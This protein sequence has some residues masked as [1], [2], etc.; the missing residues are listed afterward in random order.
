MYRILHTGMTTNYG[1]VESVVMNWYR[2]I[3]REK[4]QFD[5]LVSHKSPLIAYEYEI[6]KLGGHVYRSYYGRKE[7]PFTARKYIEEIFSNDSNI[8]GVHMNLNTL[9]YI[10]PLLVAEKKGLPVRIAHSHNT[11]N[12]NRKQHL[13]TRIM[14]S[15]NKR[16]LQSPKYT[17]MGCSVYAYEYMFGNK[18]TTVIHN[19]I[20]TEKFRFNNRRRKLLRERYGISEK[21]KVIGFIGRLQYQKNPEFL[22]RVFCEYQKKI[23]PNS[24]LMIIGTGP[25]EIKCKEMVKNLFLEDRVIFVGMINETSDYYSLFDVFL[26]PSLF[27]GLPVVLI[28]AQ[29]SSLPCL[30]SNNIRED[31]MITSLI[32]RNE[33]DDSTRNWALHLDQMVKKF[34]TLDRNKDTFVKTVSSAGYD[35]AQEVKI[36]EKM[37][38]SMIEGR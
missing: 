34:S 18:E 9:E 22:L 36:L 7:K 14:Q 28:E 35:I 4:I 10:T 15:L 1:G 31:V 37:Y 30:I 19:A 16:I 33:L 6:K 13:E 38:L 12:L 26:L 11:G 23:N 29:T 24:I 27:E 8:M 5:F 21:T 20:E 2:H 17:K 32:E 3:N 25:L